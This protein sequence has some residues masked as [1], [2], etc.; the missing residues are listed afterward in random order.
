MTNSL[1]QRSLALGFAAFLTLA[2]LGGI[3]HLAPREEP[4]GAGWA[5]KAAQPA[6][7]G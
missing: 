1:I 5:Q 4:A 7:H 3:D 6:P 2:I